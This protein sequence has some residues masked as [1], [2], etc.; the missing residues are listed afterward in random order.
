MNI[1]K[2]KDEKENSFQIFSKK[3]A[4]FSFFHYN[5]R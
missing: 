5:I 1:E 4:F 2:K 3:V